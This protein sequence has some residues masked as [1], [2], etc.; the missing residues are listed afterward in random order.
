MTGWTW[1]YID[2]YLTLPRLNALI[3]YWAQ[4]PPM[5]ITAALFAGIKPAKRAQPGE[6][7]KNA[8]QGVTTVNDA[9]FAAMLKPGIPFATVKLPK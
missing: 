4:C 8:W 5:H 6:I 1:D 9:Q 7:I 2:E 3:D